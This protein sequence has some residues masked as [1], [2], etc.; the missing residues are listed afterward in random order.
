[1]N[2]FNQIDW[3]TVKA[4]TEALLERARADLESH[5]TSIEQTEFQRGRIDALKDLIEHFEPS[6]PVIEES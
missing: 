6:T 4:K 5:G 3:M 1:M 2:Q